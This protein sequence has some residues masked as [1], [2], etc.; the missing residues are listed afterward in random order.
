MPHRRTRWLAQRPV[1]P[2]RTSGALSAGPSLRVAARTR[3]LSGVCGLFGHSRRGL[4]D[5]AIFS[6]RALWITSLEFDG[7]DPSPTNTPER[8]GGGIHALRSRPG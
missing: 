5:A 4:I 3:L 7:H 8:H 2:S 1:S 6:A